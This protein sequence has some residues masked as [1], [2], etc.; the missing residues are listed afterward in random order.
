MQTPI[1]IQDI[2]TLLRAQDLVRRLAV[3]GL[4]SA[5]E[6]ARAKLVRTK[7]RRQ[8]LQEIL[9]GNVACAV[10]T[11]TETFVIECNGNQRFHLR[12]ATMP[13]IWQIMELELG[14]DIQ[15]VKVI[16]HN[17]GSRREYWL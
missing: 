1:R 14:D 8:Y 5:I 7:G 11:A 9:P 13:L 4:D 17:G 3:E 10:P 16:H 12:N 2:R 15:A 6:T